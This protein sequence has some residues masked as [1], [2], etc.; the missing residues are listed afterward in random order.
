MRAADFLLNVKQKY[1]ITLIQQLF[2]IL[3]ELCNDQ[4]GQR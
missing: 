4:T 2:Y 1:G 3:K